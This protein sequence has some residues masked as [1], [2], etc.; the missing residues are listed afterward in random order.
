MNNDTAVPMAVDGSDLDI[1][2]PSFVV[3][4]GAS[5]GGL[6]AIEAFFENMPPDTGMCFVLIQHLSPDFRSMMDQILLRH[7]DMQIHRVENGMS[8][9]KDAIYLIPPGKS[10]IVS[11]HKLLVTEQ[12]TTRGLNLPIDDFLRS[13]AQDY[14]SR[15]IGIILSGTGSDGSR[16]VR[17]I[18]EAGGF[19]LVQE[20]ESASFDGMPRAAIK[21]GQVDLVVTPQDMP[22][23]LLKYIAQPEKRLENVSLLPSLSIEQPHLHDIFELLRLRYGIEFKYYKASTIDRRIER[24]MHITRSR[25]LSDYVNYLTQTPAELDA[26]Y[27]DL[28]IGVTRFFRDHEAFAKLSEE[29]I[30]PIVKRNVDNE[31]DIRIWLAGCATGE[32]AYS[33]AMLVDEAL[34][35]YTTQVDVK[36]FATDI[37]QNSLAKA[38]LA[39]YPQSIQ[40]DV[41]Q[42]RLERYFVLKGNQYTI[43]RDLRKLVIFAQ[44]NV[45]ND[46]PFT[47]L[48]LLVC[49]NMLIYLDASVQKKVFSLFHF[50]LKTN[51]YLFLGPSETLT[52][53]ED[54]F[55][56]I[57]LQWRI[58]R[59][60]RDIRLPDAKPMVSPRLTTT[61]PAVNTR[62]ARR[63][64]QNQLESTITWAYESMLEEFVQSGFLVDD[65]QDLLHTFGKAKHFLE[66]QEGRVNNNLL[67]L[68]DPQLSSVISAAIHRTNTE[69]KP[70]LCRSIPLVNGDE[71]QY[72]DVSVRLLRNS[73]SNN[74]FYFIGIDNIEE[75]KERHPE[76]ITFQADSHA[77]QQIQDLESELQY[78]KEHLQATN[79]ELEASNEELQAS[80]EELLATN[81][82]LQSTN[83]ELQSTNEELQS[84]NEELHSVNDELNNVN[85]LHQRKIDELVQLNNDVENLLTSTEVGTLFLDKTLRVRKFTPAVTNLFSIRDRDLGRAFRDIQNSLNCSI[86]SIVEDIETVMETDARIDR[87]VD[88]VGNVSVLL[89]ILPYHDEN[90]IIQGVVLTLVNISAIKRATRA[91]E[92]TIEKLES[93][94]QELRDFSY[95]ASHD[96]QAPLRQVT[97]FI[98]LIRQKNIDELDYETQEYFQYIQAATTKMSSLVSGLLQYS[99]LNTHGEDRKLVAMDNLLD[100]ALDLTADNIRE[101]NVIIKRTALPKLVVDPKQLRTV[102]INL[103]QNAVKFNKSKV[104]QIDISVENTDD[105]WIFSFK[106]NGIGIDRRDQD[107]IFI[108]F[109]RLHADIDYPGAGLGLAMVK[110]IIELHSGRIWVESEPDEGTTM[111]FSLPMTANSVVTV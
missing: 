12:P 17:A 108:L 91:L 32:E 79:E 94:N 20:V 31:Q 83:E 50:A 13:L 58:Y 35:E 15:S 84:T 67:N 3:G 72:L 40:E 59:K 54:E 86:D 93:R 60:R 99:R 11:N 39:S 62:Y 24:R 106:D 57:S 74:V 38:A 61:R 89:Q 69:N 36:I 102:F 43:S 5:A 53:V 68:I 42:E 88:C 55:E 78:A 85:A 66:Y 70:I 41:S 95:V 63:P 1:N 81:E 47:N 14:G 18:Q 22:E 27:H 2:A 73:R 107:K 71:K 80:N 51:G 7:T 29:I 6:E 92:K 96:L 105:E 82:E 75:V 100:Q 104:P 33:I 26:L 4:I 87:E 56:T 9:E 44:Q 101:K 64:I 103:I 97:S 45:M 16:G 98:D 30:K 76:P 21:T 65:H 10:M 49:R 8:L 46:P 34:S 109:R 77:V 37:H 28:L 111:Y 25:G 19:V 90:A 48:D 110:R 23:S 52:G